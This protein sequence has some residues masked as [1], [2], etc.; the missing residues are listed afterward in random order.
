MLHC[1]MHTRTPGI[2]TQETVYE[3]KALLKL[4]LRDASD[5]NS[6]V[7]VEPAVEAKKKRDR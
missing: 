5:P 7:A 2:S 4:Q 3:G 1:K 6:Q